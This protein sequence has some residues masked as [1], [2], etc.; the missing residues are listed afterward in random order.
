MRTVDTSQYQNRVDGF[1]FDVII[2]TFGQSL[3]PG[4]EQRDFWTSKAADTRGSRNTIGVRDPVV[5]ELVEAVIA[6]PSRESLIARTRALDRVLLW[7]HYVIPQWH[8][9]VYRVAY[10]DKFSRPAISP[11]YA[12]DL[13]TWWVDPDKAA[14]IEGRLASLATDKAASRGVAIQDRPV[15]LLLLIAISAFAL[16]IVRR[17]RAGRWT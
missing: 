17:A 1:D 3:S 4:N 8:V 15:A 5:D 9:R 7:G 12:F 14:R 13:N 16:W 10:W 6:A 2:D 11:K